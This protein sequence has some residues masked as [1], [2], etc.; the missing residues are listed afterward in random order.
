[1]WMGFADENQVPGLEEDEAVA[2]EVSA[3]LVGVAPWA[4]SLIVHAAIVLLAVFVIFTTL[5]PTPPQK[6]IIPVA[7]YSVDPGT[8]DPSEQE[9]VEQTSS[10]QRA[11]TESKV[12]NPNPSPT[13]TNAEV[14]QFSTTGAQAA[15][16]SNPLSGK[17]GDDGPGPSFYG[18]KPGGNV[19]KLVFVIDGSGSLIDT[20]PFVIQELERFINSL[21]KVQEFNVIIFQEGQSNGYLELP[22]NA[23]AR[24]GGLRHATPENKEF[25]A[26]WLQ[27]VVAQGKANPQQTLIPAMRRAIG[28]GAE[29]IY[30]LSDNITGQA[31]YELDRQELIKALQDVR[32]RSSV[33]INTI[34]FIYPDR[35][36]D[37][38]FKEP[39]LYAISK[40]TGGTYKFVSEEEARNL[41]RR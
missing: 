2:T 33:V 11:I 23:R 24:T 25:A 41:S 39:T 40:A 5:A 6:K 7:E 15:G 20:M 28:Q 31:Q 9:S 27:T 14:P 16:A 22:L 8:L 3:A 34:Q 19:K 30:L 36:L 21:D 17:V 1:M 35:L 18:T 38:G 10:S 37:A 13:K 32:Q 29:L 4:I 12:T 26:R